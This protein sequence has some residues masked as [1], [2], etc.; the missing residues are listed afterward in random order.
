MF[1]MQVKDLQTSLATM[2]AAINCLLSLAC[3]YKYVN[4]GFVLFSITTDRNYST[5]Y[6]PRC[7]AYL[8]PDI[9]RAYRPRCSWKDLKVE[10]AFHR[11]HYNSTLC[12]GFEE[13]TNPASFFRPGQIFAAQVTSSLSLNN[14]RKFRKVDFG[15]L[16]LEPISKLKTM[17]QVERLED[18]TKRLAQ[19]RQLPLKQ[20]TYHCKD[21]PLEREK[22]ECLLCPNSGTNTYRRDEWANRHF[23][24]VH[25]REYFGIIS[26][27]SCP[28]CLPGLNVNDL[29]IPW[30]RQKL[31]LS[32]RASDF[33]FSGDEWITLED[34]IED[35][36][37]PS[38]EEVAT[39]I[40]MTSE[41]GHYLAGPVMIQ[42]FIVV[43]EGD[44][45]C[46]CLGI[47][48]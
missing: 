12:P 25:W 42:R 11:D 37:I 4:K 30:E 7:S 8:S 1:G 17:A 22:V 39:I 48:T 31:S 41:V 29:M 47:H 5:G 2:L 44:G 13:Q 24:I 6:D 18:R 43:R 35:I 32:Q 19:I 16:P 27:G 38:D 45:Y 33:R 36:P 46:L 26:R 20:M 15:N 23:R 10:A 3:Y 14:N 28:P 34:V 40:A 21:M 9:F